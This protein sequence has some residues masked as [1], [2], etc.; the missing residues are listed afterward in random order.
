MYDD[1]PEKLNEETGA[2]WYPSVGNLSAT[3]HA[4]SVVGWDDNYPKENFLEIDGKKPENDGA[5]L[6]KNSYG[7]DYGPLGGYIYISYEDGYLF[8]L[9]DGQYM[10]TFSGI[11]KPVD[12]KRYTRSEFSAVSS[13]TPENDGRAVFANVYEFGA[14]EKFSEISFVTWA[15]GGQY[16]VYYAP[17]DGEVPKADESSWTKLASGE[18]EHDGRMTVK[19]DGAVPEGKGA[20]ILVLTGDNPCI[21]TDENLLLLGRPIFNGII[22]RDVSFSLTDGAFAPAVKTKKMTNSEDTYEEFLNLCIDAYTVPES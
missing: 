21:G 12:Q 11:R 3:N 9:L 16:E 14:G 15:K 5:W 17:M 10:Y 1:N 8:K 22:T 2:Y 6:I 13:W 4:V 18:V 19:A 20:L 7:T